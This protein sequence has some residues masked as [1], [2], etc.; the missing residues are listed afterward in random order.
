[1]LGLL[2]DPEDG[3]STFL[4]NVGELSDY[5]ASREHKF[6]WNRGIFLSLKFVMDVRKFVQRI[7]HQQGTLKV[8]GPMKVI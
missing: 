5:T 3:S 4:R 6:M 7:L 8:K 1:L 2:S